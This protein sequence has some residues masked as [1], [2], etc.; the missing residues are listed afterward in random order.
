MLSRLVLMIVSQEIHISRHY[1][2]YLKLISYVDY[3]SIFKI[4]SFLKS[5]ELL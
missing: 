1:A 5:L 3:I 4:P 2:T